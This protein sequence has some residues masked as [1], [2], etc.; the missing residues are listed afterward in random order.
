LYFEVIR[1]VA[2]WEHLSRLKVF[3]VSPN[4]LAVTLKG[5]AIA[6]D[7]YDMAQNVQKTIEDIKKAR[8]HFEHFDGNFE[9]VGN[10]LKK[11]QD[12]FDTAST[13]LGRYNSSVTRLTGE[14][15]AAL[16]GVTDGAGQT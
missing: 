12:A 2:L 5:I 6:H 1:N 7:Y 10:R 13:H 15:P 9:E 11:A 4:T 8:K 16:P 14:A 3:P